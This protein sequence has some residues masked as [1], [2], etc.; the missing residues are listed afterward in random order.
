M[1]DD[2]NN[3]DILFEK[4]FDSAPYYFFHQPYSNKALPKCMN[5][6]KHPVKID[7]FPPKL[8]M[9][10][11]RVPIKFDETPSFQIAEWHL[12]SITKSFSDA[13]NI[14]NG[15][16]YEKLPLTNGTE[17]YIKTDINEKNALF[18]KHCSE[19]E[20]YKC[21]S[22]L[23][24]ED[25]LNPKCNTYYE[26][27]FTDKPTV[28]YVA[29]PFDKFDY[30]MKVKSDIITMHSVWI[31][32]LSKIPQRFGK[33]VFEDE[34]KKYI[35]QDAL[36]ELFTRN[37]GFFEETLNRL[38]PQVLILTTNARKTL[39]AVYKIE[40]N[41]IEI[42]GTIYPMFMKSE[43][44]KNRKEIEQLAQLPYRGTFAPHVIPV[45]EFEKLKNK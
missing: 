29:S 14:A 28:F 1:D 34:L 37:R 25:G 30:S 24:C 40:N 2:W 3:G 7:Q 12:C 4:N 44:R 8:K 5:V 39:E 36:T 18:Y 26:Y 43:L 13:V 45:D 15:C 17:A 35:S 42:N 6:P 23:D 41:K 9:R 16:E 19:K 22:Y 38:F 10:V 11:L 21:Q 32:F 20:K 33:Y 31:P 27:C